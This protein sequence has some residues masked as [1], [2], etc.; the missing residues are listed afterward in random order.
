MIPTW[1]VW[2]STPPECRERVSCPSIIDAARAWAER[3]FKKGM[4]ARTGTEVLVRCENDPLPPRPANASAA[5]RATVVTATT[6]QVKI[7]IV[8]APAFRAS[9][10]GV[11]NEA[12]HGDSGNG[13][14]H[15]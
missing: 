4:L 1:I 11:V 3:Q 6:Y 14:R 13:A 7:T 12:I 15:G 5:S 9:L 2:S 8:N 10:V